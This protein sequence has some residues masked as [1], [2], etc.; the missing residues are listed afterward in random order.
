MFVHEAIKART[1]AKP[2]ITR[3]AWKACSSR[4]SL[5]YVRILPTN[6][7]DCCILFSSFSG[8]IPCRGWQPTA[9]DLAA[10]D[11]EIV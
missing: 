1:E 10:D 7:P 5:G 9:G 11:W 3:T 8:K 2:F 4:P 6:T